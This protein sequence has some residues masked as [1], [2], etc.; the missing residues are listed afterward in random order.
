MRQQ[1]R[2]KFVLRPRGVEGKEL[3]GA[4]ELVIARGRI[5]CKA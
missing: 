4:A 3:A 2:A 1:S 5:L